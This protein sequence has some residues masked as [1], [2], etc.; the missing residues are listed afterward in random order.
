MNVYLKT[1]GP[2]PT[3]LLSGREVSNE[4]KATYL[5]TEERFSRG[6]AAP[7][8]ESIKDPN[9]RIGLSVA[10]Y[11]QLIFFDKNFT[12]PAKFDLI[13]NIQRDFSSA[14]SRPNDFEATLDSFQQFVL[15]LAYDNYYNPNDGLEKTLEEKYFSLI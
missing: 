7:Y 12:G 4:A 6:F 1:Y 15:L 8:L 10:T 2:K 11:Q 13:G 5:L 9:D 14:T 3:H